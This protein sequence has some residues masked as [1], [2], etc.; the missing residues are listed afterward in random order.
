MKKD[1]YHNILQ[2]HAKTSDMRLIG[3]GFILQQNNDPK[4][5]F[6]KIICNH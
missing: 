6:A 4:Y 1:D 2:R 5:T 3:K